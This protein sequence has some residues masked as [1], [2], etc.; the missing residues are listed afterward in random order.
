MATQHQ[1]YD[2]STKETTVRDATAEEEA[3]TASRQAAHAARVS[4]AATQQTDADVVA[5]RAAT[6]PAYAALVRLAGITLPAKEES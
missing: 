2:C 1:V 6:D 4:S 5:A 3:E